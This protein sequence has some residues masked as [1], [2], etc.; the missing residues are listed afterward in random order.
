MKKARKAA[1]AEPA[2]REGA[3]TVGRVLATLELLAGDRNPLRLVDIA[4]TLDL[5]PSSAHALLQQLVKFEYVQVVGAERR[6]ELGPN[7]ALLGSRALSGLQLIRVAR[8]IIEELVASLGENTYLAMRH[9]RGMAYVDNVEGTYGLMMRFPMGTPRPLHASGPGKLYLAFHAG[10]A[11]LNDVLGSEPLPA[12]TKHTVTDRSQL[13]RQLEQIRERGYAI[14]EQEV[15][16]DAF[17]V[18]APIFGVQDQLIGCVTIGI[19][20]TRFKE[21]KATAIKQV[22]AAAAEIT[23]RM[24]NENWKDVIQKYRE[25]ASASDRAR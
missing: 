21:R 9:A 10:P 16:D 1:K 2:D 8:P 17:G 24:G 12:Y 13:R 5:P 15:V 19:P 22:T 4:R 11:S 23:R 20:G 6:Y 25:H 7:L 3:R 18:S 14:N